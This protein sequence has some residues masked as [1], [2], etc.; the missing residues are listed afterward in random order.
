MFC[1]KCG[2][3]LKPGTEVCSCGQPVGAGRFDGVPYTSAQPRIAP[4]AD[5]AQDA[6]PYTRTTYTGKDE[7]MQAD[8]DDDARTTYRPVYEG[9]SVPEEIRGDVRRAVD[10]AQ[11]EQ[12]AQAAQPAEED[13]LV[14]E[15][16]DE[17]E[18]GG[19]DDFDLSQLRSR[20]I[21]SDGRAGISRDVSE[22]V[23]RLEASE[24]V[25]RG[26]RRKVYGA[27]EY[28]APAGDGYEA[29]EDGQDVFAEAPEEEYGPA[30]RVNTRLIFRIIGA[31]A[32][33]AVVAVGVWYFVGNLNQAQ[34]QNSPI[35]GV[36]SDLYEQ[37][38]AL[39]QQHADNTYVQSL[40]T[41]SQTNGLLGIVAPLESDAQAIEALRPAE[42]SEADELFLSA[43]SS[44]QD[45]IYSA[46][47][48][49]ALALSDTTTSDADKAA[50]SNENWAIIHN[51]ITEL[52]NATSTAEL[53]AVIGGEVVQVNQPTAGPTPSPTPVPYT[54]LSR[55]DKNNDVIALQER[56]TELGYL[57]DSIDGNFGGNTQTAVK[58]FQSAV[59][60]EETGIADP[61]MQAALFAEDAPY[62]P[63]AQPTPTPT[64]APTPTAPPAE[65]TGAQAGS[66]AGAQA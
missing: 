8:A 37:G 31:L 9:A 29:Q 34:E 50:R 24:R 20:P 13:P 64:A 27:E 12:E 46:V 55:G 43:L 30:P 52:A 2:K 49:D 14:R 40:L 60:M 57:N 5:A 16:F 19:I 61:A 56:L 47:T 53:T 65:E 1:S 59:G 11:D 33:V 41:Q 28:A 18:G 39:I 3:T 45:N 23:E 10:G 22:Y 15:M 21:T 17:G 38:L 26:R 54:T 62:H 35:A 66:D 7:Q 4:E 48:V 63:S 32:A 42:P 44:I 25:K 6:L 51:D 36:S 58:L